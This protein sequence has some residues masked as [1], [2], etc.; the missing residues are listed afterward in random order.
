VLDVIEKVLNGKRRLI[1]RGLVRSPSQGEGIT[2]YGCRALPTRLSFRN[3]IIRPATARRWQVKQAEQPVA[4]QRVSVL[5]HL[6]TDGKI[7]ICS[8][9]IA[10]DTVPLLISLANSVRRTSPA[11]ASQSRRRKAQPGGHPQIS[12]G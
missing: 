11:F 3:T 1:D 9:P 12:V 2:D 5:A 4:A 6:D 8:I 7:S 10:A